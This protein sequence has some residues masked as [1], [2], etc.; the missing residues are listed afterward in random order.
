MIFDPGYEIGP[1]RVVRMLGRGGMGDVYE[2][3]HVGLR[4][5]YA[6]KAFSCGEDE[7]SILE[8]KFFEEGRLL[9]RLN[10]PQIVKVFDLGV[11]PLS[12]MPYFVMGLV[13]YADGESRTVEDVDRSDI[14]EAL[15]YQWFKD[16]AGALD[17]IHAQGIVHRDVK[18]NNFLLD[19]DLHATMSDFGVSRIFGE[20]M[21]KEV[22]ASKTMRLRTDDGNLVFGTERFIA[23][24]VDAGMVATPAAD[25]YSMGVMFYRLLTDEWY[26]A[27]VD[28][29][30]KLSGFKLHWVPVLSG[31]LASKP[32]NR[33]EKLFP[34][35]DV[36]KETLQ[37]ANPVDSTVYAEPESHRRNVTH[38]VSVM[39]AISVALALVSAWAIWF[40]FSAAG[41]RDAALVQVDDLRRRLSAVEM[42]LTSSREKMEES[43]RAVELERS[44][45]EDAEEALE[46]A[47]DRVSELEDA[48]RTMSDELGRLKGIVEELNAKRTEPSDAVRKEE[49]PAR[50]NTV[51]LVESAEDLGPIPKVGYKW[52]KGAKR[53]QPLSVKFL[54]ANNSTVDLVPV[55]AGSFLMTNDP[56]D[57]RTHH[58]VSITRPFWIARSLVGTEQWREYEPGVVGVDG[59]FGTGSDGYGDDVRPAFTRVQIDAFCRY[60]TA[61]YR[62]Q[63]PAGCVFRLPTEAEWEYCGLDGKDAVKAVCLDTVSAD[64]PYDSPETFEYPLESVDPLQ[65]VDAPD[66]SGVRQ[67]C[68]EGPT[69]RS[70]SDMSEHNPFRFVVGPDLVSERV[71]ETCRVDPPKVQSPVRMVKFDPKKVKGPGFRK[72]ETSFRLDNGAHIA[73]CA[74][75]ASQEGG[76]RMSNLPEQSGAD[77]AVSITRPFWITR[78][79]IGADQWRDFGPYD[80]EGA[81]RELEEL[82]EREIRQRKDPYCIC[83]MRN[84]AQWTAYCRH[85]TERYGK[86]LPKGYVFRLP[87]EAE[88]EYAMVANAQ[89]GA[90][91]LDRTKFDDYDDTFSGPLEKLM[92]RLGRTKSFSDAQQVDPGGLYKGNYIG[93]RTKENSWGVR[94]IVRMECACLDTFDA[95]PDASPEASLEYPDDGVEVDPL[96]RA[97]GSAGSFLVRR[98]MRE[99]ILAPLERRV[100]AHVVI[101]P[102]ME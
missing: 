75:P 101:A 56:R 65:W 96:R 71:W 89:G 10:H 52:L 37:I 91:G 53:D 2:V 98:N 99:R 15:V 90:G 83:V 97:S 25:A 94:D 77:H 100:L 32:E 63:L 72:D 43:S 86:L 39:S 62:T 57:V 58:K 42:E 29:K 92:N 5:R 11:E 69:S 16:V 95:S 45:R 67:V 6:L 51:D 50:T 61:K 24:E 35:K 81:T 3:E 14:T 48:G 26:E 49:K 85:L 60:L 12:K 59:A 33:P 21:R 84:H 18:P 9:S 4:V 93:G 46:E 20:R 74:C 40:G 27:G 36:L 80:C 64:N 38:P 31:L 41:E 23:P 1:Y 73:F 47:E 82:L 87:T 76:F 8:K 17:Y 68:R 19:A 79:C 55:K 28:L 13:L 66:V 34:L 44:A 7:L 30:R 70:S 102:A 54:F 78:Y 22:N 88:L